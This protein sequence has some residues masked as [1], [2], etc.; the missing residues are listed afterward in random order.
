MVAVL[1]GSARRVGLAGLPG[2]VVV[3]SGIRDEMS[4]PAIIVGGAIVVVCSA[5][6]LALVLGLV[7]GLIAWCFS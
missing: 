4:V 3:M 6:V 5:I 7:A 2:S 1:P